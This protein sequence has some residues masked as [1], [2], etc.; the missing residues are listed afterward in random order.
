M[1]KNLTRFPHFHCQKMG[2]GRRFFDTLVLKGTFDLRPGLLCPSEEQA[3]IVL[4]DRYHEPGNASRSS[5]SHAGEVVLRKPTTDILVTGSAR[6][7]G[8][9]ARTEWECSVSVERRS[10]VLLRHA[11]TATGPRS[12]VHRA[13]R[14][15]TVSDPEPAVEVPIRYELSY[16]GSYREARSPPGTPRFVVHRPNPSGTGLFD[17]DALDRSRAYPAPRWQDRAQPVTQINTDSPLVGFGPVARMWTARLRHAGTYDHA[18]EQRMRADA[19]RG[20][21]PD[22]PADFDPRFFQ[23]AHPALVTRE[24][25]Q[26]DERLWLTGLLPDAGPVGLAL[27]GFCPRARLLAPGRPWEERPLALDTVHIDLDASR[28]HLCFRITLEDREDIRA[29]VV[30]AETGEDRAQAHR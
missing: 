21:V 22:Y 1:V 8:G 12:F 3:P 13:L 19:E 10:A 29:A 23:C 11:A 28:V 9:R 26:G 20:L 30:V 4:A 15:W 18:W 25:L 7:P 5:L 27:P 2:A 14:G 17:E 24:P 16:G 6:S